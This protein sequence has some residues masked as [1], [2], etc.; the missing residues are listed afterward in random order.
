MAYNT[1]EL[2]RFL[3]AQNKLYLT[4][5]SEIKKGKK[6]YFWDN[7]LRNRIIKNF[8]PIELRDDIGSLWENFII[9]E[10]KKK[11][12]YENQFK[13]TFFWRNTQQAEIDFLEIKNNE[14]EAF[15]IKYNPNGLSLWK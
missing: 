6:I 12:S 8:N 9:S 3:D 4:A 1:K 11:L 13:D 5:Y 15:E 2:V 14:I 10:R 7:G